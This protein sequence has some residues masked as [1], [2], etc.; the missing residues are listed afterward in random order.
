VATSRDRE[1]PVDIDQKAIHIAFRRSHADPQFRARFVGECRKQ[2]GDPFVMNT[3]EAIAI[4]RRCPQWQRQ[5]LPFSS[6]QRPRHRGRWKLCGVLGL[7]GVLAFKIGSTLRSLPRTLPKRL[8]FPTR[9]ARIAA[10]LSRRQRCANW[11]RSC[12]R[13]PPTVAP[14]AT[15]TGQHRDLSES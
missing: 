1:T 10:E 12:R 15:I 3:D 13:L 11:R 6:R 2:Q 8:R 9:S 4:V 5:H 14:I 7:Q